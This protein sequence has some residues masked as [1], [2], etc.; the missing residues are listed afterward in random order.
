MRIV[1][2]CPRP[3]QR[4][5]QPSS[6]EPGDVRPRVGNCQQNCCPRWRV[7]Q[8]LGPGPFPVGDERAG[9]DAVGQKTRARTW[10]VS[11]SRRTTPNPKPHSSS[12][13]RAV[14]VCNAAQRHARIPV[15]NSVLLPIPAAPSM[16]SR[17]PC[18]SL[19]LRSPARCA[20]APR[21]APTGL[22]P[23]AASPPA[24]PEV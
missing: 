6:P 17:P 9:Q 12:L 1:Q 21:R 8:D 7:Y 13:L 18:P 24:I 19:G 10:R 2:S 16:T 5:C 22:P 3:V 14:N 11:S 15:C 4:T 23:P 20:Q